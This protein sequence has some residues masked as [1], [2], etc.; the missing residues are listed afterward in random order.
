MPGRLADQ[1]GGQRFGPMFFGHELGTEP[2]SGKFV[3]RAG[4]NGRELDR[5]QPPEI[6]LFFPQ[7]FQEEANAVAAGENDPVVLGESIDRGIYWCPI[8]GGLDPDRRLNE[9][10]RPQRGQPIAQLLGLVARAGD[11]HSDTVKWQRGGLGHRT[12]PA[13]KAK[14]ELGVVLKS[15]A[16]KMVLYGRIAREE[17]G[18]RPFGVLMGVGQA[19]PFPFF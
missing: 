2:K 8:R 18:G 4:P 3:G 16:V 5:R 9:N 19:T 7:S 6:T 13:G 11:K 15:Q 10:L 17:G 1:R 14:G 12:C